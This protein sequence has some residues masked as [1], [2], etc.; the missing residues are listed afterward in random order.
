VT[1]IGAHAATTPSVETVASRWTARA[2]FA[3]ALDLLAHRKLVV[4]PLISHRL[5]AAGAVGV[6]EAIVA[7][8]DQY[9]GVLLDWRA[10]ETGAAR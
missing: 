2:N 4:G 8:P 1:I 3:L 10:E 7:H 5:P 6:Y 9:L